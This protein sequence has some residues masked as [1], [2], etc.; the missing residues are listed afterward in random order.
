[1]K[2]SHLKVGDGSQTAPDSC[3]LQE[4]FALNCP[5]HGLMFLPQYVT[6]QQSHK[7]VWFQ[8]FYRTCQGM[9][10]SQGRWVTDWESSMDFQ[11]RNL[12]ETMW[13]YLYGLSL[14]V[15]WVIDTPEFQRMRHIK[16]LGVCAQVFPGECSLNMHSWLYKSCNLQN[17]IR[18]CDTI[19]DVLYL[20]SWTGAT[21]NRFFHS[22]GTAYLAM[23]FI[24]NL[25]HEQPHL[26]V[27]DRDEM[28]VTLAG[29][30]HDLGHPCFSHSDCLEIRVVWIPFMAVVSHATSLHSSPKVQQ[31]SGHMFESS[32][33]WVMGMG[34]VVLKRG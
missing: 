5:V 1:M 33:S 23:T 4:T 10:V 2:F 29:L 15:K 22:I 25:R 19:L 21:H 16:Q 9:L 8:S 34:G 7:V 26:Q 11:G 12:S 24:Q 28:C 18:Y 13:F 31:F 17:M 3:A 20:C 6:K 14:E 30:C 32:L 27:T